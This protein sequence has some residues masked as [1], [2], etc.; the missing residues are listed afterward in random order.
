MQLKA[1]PAAQGVPVAVPVA[2]SLLETVGMEAM[3]E[4]GE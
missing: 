2:V 3:A 4:P 1:E